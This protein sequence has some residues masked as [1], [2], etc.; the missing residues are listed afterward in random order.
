MAQGLLLLLSGS[1]AEMSLSCWLK[2]KAKLLSLHESKDI[3]PQMISTDEAKKNKGKWKRNSIPLG[4]K[5]KEMKYNSLIDSLVSYMLS[6]FS[7]FYWPTSSLNQFY[8]FLL[9]FLYTLFLATSTTSEHSTS[10]GINPAIL[11]LGALSV[12]DNIWPIFYQRKIIG[13]KKKI[14]KA[15]NKMILVSALNYMLFTAQRSK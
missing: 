8:S 1:P 3:I 12:K 15:I 9:I 13:K 11:R 4:K 7:S 6:P 2:Q 14:E 5:K 10:S